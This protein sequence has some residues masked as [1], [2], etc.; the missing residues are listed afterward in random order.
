MDYFSMSATM[1]LEVGHQF[2]IVV[3]D[4]YQH[5]YLL[6]PDANDL[7]AIATYIK[8][9][10]VSTAWLDHLTAHTLIGK[11]AQRPGKDPSKERKGSQLLFWKPCVTTT[12]SFGMHPMV[13][14]VV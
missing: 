9:P 14:Q 12:C 10:M 8:K 4:L 11:I 2:D 7:K 5:E 3:A 1:F 13:M 6:V